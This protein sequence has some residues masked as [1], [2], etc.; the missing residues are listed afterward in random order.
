M[1]AT[2]ILWGQVLT[3]CSIALAFIW[4]AT[5]WTAAQLGYQA[6]LG[7]PWFM[8]GHYP[9]VFQIAA[10]TAEASVKAD[11]YRLIYSY[12][13]RR[14][15][16][17]LTPKN[18]NKTFGRLVAAML[19]DGVSTSTFAAAFSGQRGDTVRFPDDAQLRAAIL[20]N[21]V[22]LWFPRKERLA[23]VLW[24]LGCA[25]RTKYS[26]HTPRPGNMSIEHVL[27]Q[28]WTTFWNLPD[29]RRAPADRITGVDETMLSAIA[30]RQAAL[31]TLGNLTLITVPGNTTASNSAF[32]Q[33]RPWL[34]QSLLALNLAILENE[35]W[36]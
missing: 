14:A 5:Q 20:S 33:K 27:P 13:V 17:G 9:L 16:C 26:V 1:N 22:Y 36:D 21:P 25:S 23:D 4:A 32:D 3:V 7:H 10:S 2:R 29:G 6:Q 28:T 18:L 31:H 35:H 19:T 11:L 34:K 24:E 30:V 8:A 12:L 15:L